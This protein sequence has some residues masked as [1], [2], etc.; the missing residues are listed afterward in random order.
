[1]LQPL[2]QPLD[3]RFA[4]KEELLVLGTK[5]REASEGTAAIIRRRI[6]AEC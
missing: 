1:M 4:P 6:F 3:E 2:L 5:G